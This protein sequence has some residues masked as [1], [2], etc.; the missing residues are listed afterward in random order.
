[1]KRLVHSNKDEL[2]R[3]FPVPKLRVGAKP[4]ARGEALWYSVGNGWKEFAAA[5]L[6]KQWGANEF[7]LELD[8]AKM[9]IPRTMQDLHDFTEKYTA[10][11]EGHIDWPHVAQDHGGIEISPECFDAY[12]EDPDIVPWL[13][14]WDVPSGCIWD[15]RV[16]L[17]V[18]KSEKQ[19]GS[20]GPNIL[21]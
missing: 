21:S 20:G 9:F 7:Q 14:G 5:R 1:M 8:H 10:D 3:T 4:S 16:I 6:P 15:A 11:E 19:T 2:D 13:Y 12:C 17:N 18:T